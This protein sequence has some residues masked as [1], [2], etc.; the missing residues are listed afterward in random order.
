MGFGTGDSHYWRKLIGGVHNTQILMRELLEECLRNFFGEEIGGGSGALR[1]PNRKN[2]EKL[3][4]KND[5]VVCSL[6]LLSFLWFGSICLDLGPK[7]S[8]GS[9]LVRPPYCSPH[10]LG[11]L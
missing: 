5:F 2:K 10:D 9:S 7:S 1:P 8:W 11:K 3:G 6:F 4:K